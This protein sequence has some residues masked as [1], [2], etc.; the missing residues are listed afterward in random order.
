[1]MK[2]YMT[3][4]LTCITL[5]MHAGIPSSIGSAS[6]SLSIYGSDAFYMLIPVGSGKYTMI[7][8]KRGFQSL[9]T[10]DYHYTSPTASLQVTDGGN[11]PLDFQLRYVQ[12]DA[13]VFDVTSPVFPG[14][15]S[16]EFLALQGKARG[17][18]NGYTLQLTVTEGT[19]P[20]ATGRNSV[21]MFNKNG[22]YTAVGYFANVNSIGTY[23]YRKLNSSTAVLYLNDYAYGHSTIYLPFKD[24]ASGIYAAVQGYDAAYNG[25]YYYKN[26]K[27]YSSVKYFYYDIWYGTYYYNT[28]ERE[29]WEWHPGYQIGHFEFVKYQ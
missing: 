14:S 6:L 1:M 8:V 29:D 18:I 21:L 27:W 17:S 19:R 3:L 2:R 28:R 12:G 20:F 4:V 15:S 22:T 23:Y 13:G 10:Y 26:N 5:L 7:D 11:G 9:G 25:F 24:N 16:G